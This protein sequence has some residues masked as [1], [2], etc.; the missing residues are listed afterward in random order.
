[1][2]ENRWAVFAEDHWTV[3]EKTHLIPF[4]RYDH[5]SISG[6]NVSGGLNFEQGI[7]AN[8]RIK[9]GI[10]RAYKAPSLYQTHPSYLIAT[11]G[12]GCPIVP[13]FPTT[14]ACYYL[15]NANLKPE[16]ALNKE[17]GFE[18]AKDGWSASMAYFHNAYRNKIIIGRTLIGTVAPNTNVLQ[19]ENS[20]TATV[21]GFEGNIT[22][23]LH[24]TLKWS[25]NFTYMQKS[26]DA[27]GNPLSLI[28][29]YTLNSTAWSSS[30]TNGRLKTGWIPPNWAATA[31]GAS[32]PATTGTAASMCAWASATCLTNKS[33][34]PAGA[35]TFT[36][37]M[38]AR[39][40]AA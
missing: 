19:W 29:K 36:T 18:F 11:R 13:G 5:S 34:A 33:T 32:T 17:L 21:S 16:T 14:G 30:A 1:M 8:W 27:D 24:R 25:N 23:P 2:A 12:K 6:G 10:A 15:G 31:C 35:R 40:T 7:G 39:F 28:P 22:V 3:R 37:N 26:E 38:A 9:G 4:L 20:P